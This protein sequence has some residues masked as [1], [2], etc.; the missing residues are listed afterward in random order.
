MGIISGSKSQRFWGINT[1]ADLIPRRAG[2]AAPAVVPYVNDTV[3]LRH[4]AVWAALRLRAD[5]ISTLPVDVFRKVQL[6]PGETPIQIEAP[7]TPVLINPGGERIGLVEW[8]YSSQVEL[9]RSGNSIGII[10]EVDGAGFPARIDL[11]PSS[12]CAVGVVA[13]EL[14][15]YRIAGKKYPVN[16]IWHERQYTTSGCHVGLSPVMNAAY[17]IG[18]YFS[19][20]DFVTAWFTGGA[21]PRARL[22]N[23]EKKLVAK[24]ATV[25]KE[26]WRAAIAMGEPFVHGTD[27][28]YELIQ[29]EQASADWLEAMRFSNADIAR[30]FGVPADL[31]DAAVSSKTITYASITERNLQFLIMNLGPAIIRRET[32]LSSLLPR[33]RYVKFNSDA[34]L[35]MDPASRAEM[36][37]TRIESYVLAPSEGRAL[38]DLPPFTASQ[39]EEFATF[40]LLAP[41]P[42]EPSPSEPPVKE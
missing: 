30:F 6:V 15:Y 8:L 12:I 38:E 22:K 9:D 29:A 39:L 42:A 27:W 31:I 21:V 2:G 5:L 13:G 33:P 1:P 37:K 11:Q 32:A 19:V 14:N 10:R 34:I 16:Q 3:A 41:T 18:E 17:T 23:T 40:G 35:R 20:Q 28:E 26:A 24:E 25:V 36:I 7:K 4:S